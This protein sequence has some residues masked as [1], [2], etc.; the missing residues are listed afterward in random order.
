MVDLSLDAM[1][2]KAI[3]LYGLQAGVA[4]LFV[5]LG[6]QYLDRILHIAEKSVERKND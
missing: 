5:K 2:I 1:I 6:F 3:E 4:L